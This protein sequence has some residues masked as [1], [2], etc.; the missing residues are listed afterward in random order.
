[1][2]RSSYFIKSY[3]LKYATKTN[4]EFSIITQIS[5]AHKVKIINNL[6]EIQFNIEIPADSFRL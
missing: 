6:Y 4:S 1:M 3:N 5:S 2:W